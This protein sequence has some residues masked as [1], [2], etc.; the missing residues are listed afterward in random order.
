MAIDLPLLETTSDRAF[1]SVCPA[2]GERVDDATYRFHDSGSCGH[3]PCLCDLEEIDVQTAR[4]TQGH[5]FPM[6]PSLCAGFDVTYL[7]CPND[8]RARFDVVPRGGCAEVLGDF[9]ESS[10]VFA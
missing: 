1:N 7:H 2:C 10:S 3:A 4:T 8:G 5:C 9:V 6:P